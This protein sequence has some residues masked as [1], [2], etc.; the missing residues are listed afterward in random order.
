MR[1][2]MCVAAAVG[3]VAW[4]AFSTNGGLSQLRAEEHHE[5]GHVGPLSQVRNGITRLHR[6]H[7]PQ[8]DNIQANNKT[9]ITW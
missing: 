5:A 8:T 4:Y 1:G 3:S 6:S 7:T 9:Y 2:G